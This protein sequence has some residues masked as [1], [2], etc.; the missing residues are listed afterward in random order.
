M[1]G[2]SYILTYIFACG[3]LIVLTKKAVSTSETSNSARTQDA[4]SQ[5][6][7]RKGILGGWSGLNMKPENES[8]QPSVPV[9]LINNFRTVFNIIASGSKV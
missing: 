3:L 8:F 6:M 7:M 4:T 5:K 1:L 9:I 2:S